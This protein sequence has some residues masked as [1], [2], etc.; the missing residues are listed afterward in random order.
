MATAHTT[1]HGHDHGHHGAHHN[2]GAHGSVKSY[3]VGFVLSVILTAIPFGLVMSGAL[4][5][6]TAIPVCF[7]L[8][9]VQIIVHLVYF[10][11]MNSS[12]ARSWNMAAFLFTLLIVAI[13]VVGSWWVML[14]LN[15]NMMPG[16]MPME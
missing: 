11:H 12:S 7:G 14:H 5:A 9:I 6:G 3:I 15:A 2:E 16:A 13:L 4:P 10:L 1:A 8:G